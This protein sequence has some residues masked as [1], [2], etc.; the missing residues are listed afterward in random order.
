MHVSESIVH[1]HMSG[2]EGRGPPVTLDLEDTRLRYDTYHTHSFPRKFGMAHNAL[3][4]SDHGC[5]SVC[6]NKFD[7]LYIYPSKSLL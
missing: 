6:L 3:C 4:A 1:E 7:K 2:L 5:T